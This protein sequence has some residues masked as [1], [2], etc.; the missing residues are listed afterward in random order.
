MGMR[1]F[2]HGVEVAVNKHLHSASHFVKRHKRRIYLDRITDRTDD[3]NVIR[4]IGKS[5][6]WFHGISKCIGYVPTDIADKL[7]RANMED[8]VKVRLQMISIDGKQSINIRFDIL[9]PKDDYVKY[10]SMRSNSPHN[11]LQ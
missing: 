9:G 10:S 4:V 6:G 2:E 7:V 5:N 3:R 8:K 1:V 11:F